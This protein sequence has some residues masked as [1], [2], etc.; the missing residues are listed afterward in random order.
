MA[1]IIFLCLVNRLFLAIQILQSSQ[2][3]AST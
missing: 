2:F 1:K 3:G